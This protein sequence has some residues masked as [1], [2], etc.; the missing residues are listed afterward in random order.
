MEHPHR[1]SRFLFE[2][3]RTP[4]LVPRRLRDAVT[5]AFEDLVDPGEQRELG[6]A[7][8]I[9]RP[10]GCFKETGEPDA[11]PLLSY[12]AFSATARRADSARR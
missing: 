5:R 11:T 2:D 9:E 6:M 1:R 10:L 4:D 12:E 8:F 7:L 3:L